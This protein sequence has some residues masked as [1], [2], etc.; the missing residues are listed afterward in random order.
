MSQRHS[1]LTPEPL[2]WTAEY[3][4]N[5]RRISK[6]ARWFLLGNLLVSF[7]WA[8]FM[9][10]FN[11][12]LQERG[13]GEGTIGRV[14]SSQSFGTVFLALPAATLVARLSPRLMM[15]ISALGVAGA[16]A[17]QTYA[18]GITP[19]LI[20][21]F[22]GGMM[23]AFGRVMSSPY[24]M[25]YST[26][27]ERSHVFSLSF[28]VMLGAGIIA[29][30]G[31]GSLHHYLSGISGSQVTAYRWV[32]SMACVSAAL[33]V[34]AYSRIP[35]AIVG[36]RKNRTTWR[37][38]WPTR[39]KMLFRLTLPSFVI[40][41]GA[42]LIIP[43]LNLYFRNRFGLSTQ[44]IGIYYGLAQT[45]MVLGVM[46]GPELARRYGMVRTIVA[47]EIASLPFMVILA[48]SH[49]LPLVT[50]AFLVRGA[51][52]NLGVPIANNY[53]M[54]R[55]GSADRAL[56]NSWQM[57]A[58]TLSWALMAGMG[59]WMIERWGFEL[60]LLISSGL[61]VAA[62]IIYFKFFGDEEIYA[63]KPVASTLQAGEE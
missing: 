60:P 58:W 8:T 38:F 42:G 54:E 51:L 47:T 59:G 34:F 27:A 25:K 1:T 15:T 14:L 40:G 49:N 52:M 22:S 63:G 5:L 19:I 37:E 23:L 41:L 7:A 45:S 46:I 50:V 62:S 56:A 30:F 11:L 26:S 29:H 6:E 10:L 31:A 33:A 39:G 20:A 55:V 24:L 17:W 18:D 57:L 16:F 43:F 61:Y 9:L 48:F 12:Y 13:F 2:H 35:S 32:L 53:V 4:G 36:K 21:A 28:A 44:M 3:V